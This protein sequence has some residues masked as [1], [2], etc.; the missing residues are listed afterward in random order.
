MSNIKV[1]DPFT[2]NQIAAGEVVERPAS[3]VKELC[4][5][6]LDAGASVI[7]ISIQNGGIVSI[8][9]VDNGTGMDREDAKVA[10]LRHA[11][12]KLNTI[13]DFDTIKTMGFRGEALASI[14][15]VSKIT[16]KTKQIGSQDGTTV[17][18]EDGKIIE[19]GAA[20]CPEGTNILVEYLFYNTPARYK[21]LK[22]DSTEGSYIT[23]IIERFILARP[24]VSFRLT[25]N[26]QEILHSPGNNDLKSAIFAVYGKTVT[27]ALIPVSYKTD[28]ILIEGFVGKPEICRNTR[29]NQSVFVNNRYV[30]SKTISAAIEEG[31]KTLLMKGKFAFCVINLTISPALVDVNVHPQKTEVKFW[32]DQEIFLSV[33]HATKE[34]LSGGITIPE[35]LHGNPKNTEPKKTDEDSDADSN[36]NTAKSSINFAESDKNIP[37]NADRYNYPVQQEIKETK[38]SLIFQ[39]TPDNKNN[40]HENPYVQSGISNDHY[41]NINNQSI[42]S[43]K[44]FL[45]ADSLTTSD[46]AYDFKNEHNLNISTTENLE[47]ANIKI[48]ELANARYIGSLFH[49]YLLL[50]LD[51]NLILIDQH[52]AHERILFEKLVAKHK[53]KIP[54]AQHLLTSEIIG[55]TAHEVAFVN[56]NIEILSQ[57]GFECEVFG[58]QSVVLRTVPFDI[59]IIDIRGAFRAVIDSMKTNVQTDEDQIS[60]AFYSIACKAAVKAN[61]KLDEIEISHL[62]EELRQIP[63]PTH[64]P[65]GR[66]I[67]LKMSKYEIEKSFKRIVT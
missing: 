5:N 30:K 33:L 11:T 52:A 57:I 32:N 17:R 31:Y 59:K 63:N 18:I 4:E 62:L 13:Q 46:N 1:L 8:A 45:N 6:A 49:T 48:N 64:C 9:V 22:K 12:S 35:I 66:P 42:V 26:G 56:E 44:Q 65:H 25:Q 51:N 54:I 36:I 60:S 19:H 15:S 2:A 47:Q 55:L 58:T 14:A 7:S 3:V 10:F 20:G 37:S 43:D 23:D 53:N 16:L 24:D 38:E 67:V 39:E 50:E 27:Q 29:Q 61:D 40:Q 34:A 21:F 41:G 28:R